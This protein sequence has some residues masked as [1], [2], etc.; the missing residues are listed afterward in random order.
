[1]HAKCETWGKKLIEI[2]CVSVVLV[3]NFLRVQ[4]HQEDNRSEWDKNSDKI[5]FAFDRDPD[6]FFSF[7]LNPKDK[8]HVVIV[9]R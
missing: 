7:L 8:L 5:T 3:L 1:M 2:N 4:V 6:L 9:S